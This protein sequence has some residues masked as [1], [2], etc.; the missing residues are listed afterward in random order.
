MRF[1]RLVSL[2]LPL[3]NGI[4]RASIDIE[5]ISYQFSQ[6]AADEQI[7]TNFE[8]SKLQANDAVPVP[9]DRQK[10][11]SIQALQ[12]FAASTV[13]GSSLA[14]IDVLL[15]FTTASKECSRK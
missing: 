9:K 5:A 10:R 12:I 11:G 15:P 14:T 6:V 4:I 13:E 1:R 3:Q 8:P 7:V 2:G